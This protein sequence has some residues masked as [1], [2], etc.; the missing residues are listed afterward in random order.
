MTRA[1]WITL[2]VAT[3]LAAIPQ[4]GGAHA[5]PAAAMQGA[6]GAIPGR[7]SLADAQ[8]I[9]LQNHPRIASQGYRAQASGEAVKETQAELYPQIYGSAN[10]VFGGANTRVTAPPSGITDPSI[11]ARAAAGVSVSQ[12]ITDFGRQS[13]LIAA[14]KLEL[15]SEQD[16]VQ[17]VRDSVFFKATQAYYDVL[18][19]QALLAVARQT[20][21]SRSTLNQQ[22]SQLRSAKLKS[23]LDVS[24][25]KLGLDQA[26]LLESKAQG[27]LDDAWA[28]LAEA[29][30]LPAVRHF[31][32][33]DLHGQVRPPPE[34]RDEAISLALSRNPELM[35]RDA[36]RQAAHRQADADAE[37]GLPV[38]SAQAFAGVNPMRE[39]DQRLS[40]S[41]GAAGIFVTIPI[42]TGGRLTAE[43]R[44]SDYK[45]KAADR[46]L[47]AERNQ[48][49][50]DVQMAWDSAQTAYRNI[51]VTSQLLESSSKAQDLTHARYDIGSSSIVEV[52]QAEVAALEARIAQSNATYDYLIERAFLAYREGAAA[53]TER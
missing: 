41:Y 32:L 5:D 50:R 3:L 53:D 4:L 24:F 45:A 29:L 36:A 6:P 44:R 2:S 38:I 21:K 19:A 46:D 31:I 23:D 10:R 17:S 34:S 28:E 49:S 14:S 9:A 13:D 16:R 12:L 8:A 22:V 43:K 20:I 39:S 25:A 27:N 42:F 33:T 11:F 35:A 18:R 48:L 47:D 30:G 7:L 51:A 1:L 26:N 40:H 15:K 37:A 52:E